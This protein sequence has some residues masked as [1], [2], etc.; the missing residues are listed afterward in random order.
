MLKADAVPEGDRGKFPQS[1]K[2]RS[3]A[4]P[5]PGPLKNIF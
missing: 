1:A 2:L 3:V 5:I 4:D